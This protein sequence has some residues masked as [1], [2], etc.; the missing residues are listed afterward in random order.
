MSTCTNCG[1]KLVKHE[2]YYLCQSCSSKF[3]TEQLDSK[4]L[5][6]M[7]QDYVDEDL[8]DVYWNLLL[9]NQYIIFETDGKG[10]QFPAFYNINS[11]SIF[12]SGE[13]KKAVEYATKNGLT[14]RIEVYKNLAQKITDNKK[15]YQDIKEKTP[16][17]DVFICFKSTDQNGNST[18]DKQ[19]ATD[20][21]NE[22]NGKYKVFFSEKT[23]ANIKSSYRDYEPNIYYGLYTAK[24]M[25][26]ICSK[27][28][29]LESTWLKNEWSRFG[30]MNS[31]TQKII[32][33]I[34]TED[35]NPNDLPE[36]LWHNQGLK[37]DIKLM[38]NLNNQLKTLFKKETKPKMSPKKL[39]IIGC[40]IALMIGALI[41]GIFL[42][43]YKPVNYSKNTDGTYA[44][45]T[46]K[47]NKE[48]VIIEATIN[49][50][51]V[52]TI[53]KRAFSASSNMKNL[54]I[55]QTIT[56]IQ[57]SAFENCS[58]LQKVYYD[59]SISSWSQITFENS[60]SNPMTYA[61]EFYVK[62]GDE[63]SLVE[64]LSIE[65]SVIN[66][67]AFY[68][69]TSIK[70]ITLSENLTYIGDFAFYNVNKVT[71]LTIPN[72]VSYIG[73]SAFQ[74]CK[75]IQTLTIPFV[76]N[77]KDQSSKSHIGYIFGAEDYSLNGSALPSSLTILNIN[78]GKIFNNALR[79]CKNLYQVKL[80]DNVM[81]LEDYAFYNCEKLMILYLGSNTQKIGSRAF[82][83]C[84]SLVS[85]Y[86]NS[87]LSNYLNIEFGELD[88]NPANFATN[89]F[90]DN[91]NIKKLETLDISNLKTIPNDAFSGFEMTS[92]VFS[93]SLTE[94]GQGAFSKC[95]NLTSV[96]IPESVTEIGE[97][98]FSYCSGLESATLPSRITRIPEMLFNNCTKLT[99]VSFSDNVKYIGSSAFSGAKLTYTTYQ[100]CQYLASKTNPYHTA[101][102]V[103]DTS[104]TELNFH[105]DTKI[106]YSSVCYGMIYLPSITLPSNLTYIGDSAFK[107]CDSLLSI[108]LPSG[109][110]EIGM[111]VF[112]SCYN[113]VSA[114]IGSVTKMS[115]NVFDNCQNLSSVTLS[116]NLKDI[117]SNTFNYCKKLLN[118]TLPK[119]LKSINDYAFANCN[120]FEEV[121]FNNTLE[122]WCDISFSP[123]GVT[124]TAIHANAKKLF[125]NGENYKSKSHIDFSGITK[126]SAFAF[127]NFTNISSVS[128][129]SSLTSIGSY[130]FYMS[131]ITSVTLP[132]SLK[133][134]GANAFAL[135]PLTS[136]TF[137]DP[138][139]WFSTS[140]NTSSDTSEEFNNPISNVSI[141]Q[142]GKNLYK[143]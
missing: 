41:G 53:N 47:G 40:S 58:N 131:G 65:S 31:A 49:G 135:S 33:P 75:S 88:A 90:V 4:I 29:Y 34:F 61:E 30:K 136:V 18:P 82:D 94:I 141:V 142:S 126:I 85:V 7:L 44:V 60:L 113:L 3:Y 129:S 133:N 19:L 69:F 124:S 42:L 43:T 71:Q 73:F 107:D 127:G 103:V 36:E 98:A 74:N 48:E 110:T 91:V 95:K 116:D 14:D 140:S 128:F 96:V 97:Y 35:F 25:L 72:Q 38:N 89:F 101:I 93:D 11:K 123:D 102:K 21:Y 56:S 45:V 117:P 81:I 13:Y 12:E 100:N 55:P 105:P 22:L 24:V 104:V 130:A 80:S 112:Q 23:L 134:L 115:Y 16:P 27:K 139:N 92:V 64:E 63:Y 17:F 67:Y 26:L 59:G 51:D 99:S 120:N 66:S 6:K 143:K 76:G 20:I 111:N 70:N 2:G 125:I 28:E 52:T 86:Y 9:C 57:E 37:S 119:N 1:G 39:A 10:E 118:I 84:Y 54:T 106:L 137:E 132:S 15:M 109:V 78:G 68:N 87:S 83:N 121:Y 62:N 46:P 77:Q 5:L 122:A 32:I 79:N 138:T 108:K 50:K 114:D 8:S